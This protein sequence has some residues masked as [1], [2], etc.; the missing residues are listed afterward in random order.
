MQDPST[1]YTAR[2]AA[3]RLGIS[4]QTLA[5]WRCHGRGPSYYAVGPGGGRGRGNGVRYPRAELDAYAE[6]YTGGPNN[7]EASARVRILLA[8]HPDLTHREIAAEAGCH[9]SL[10]SRV[11]RDMRE[12]C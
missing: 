9:P 1:D 8:A 12:R 10:V 3:E 11:Q 7:G 2:Q 6:T 5:G 4:M